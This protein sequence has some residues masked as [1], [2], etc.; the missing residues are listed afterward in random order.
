MRIAVACQRWLCVSAS[1]FCKGGVFLQ[2]HGATTAAASALWVVAKRQSTAAAPAAGRR[3]FSRTVRDTLMI[4]PV[5]IASHVHTVSR[6][7]SPATHLLVLQSLRFDVICACHCIPL[8]VVSAGSERHA[9][10]VHQAQSHIRPTQGY[11]PPSSDSMSSST[12]AIPDRSHWALDAGECSRGSTAG[13][14][15]AVCSVPHVASE[16]S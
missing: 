14:R 11:M 8:T 6:S 13:M 4:V 10:A 5:A 15:H 16:Q 9:P 7:L 12:S 1:D 3:S 2:A